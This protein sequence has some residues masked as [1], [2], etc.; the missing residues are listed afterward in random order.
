MGQHIDR[1]HIDEAAAA[2]AAGG[3]GSYGVDNDD[4]GGRES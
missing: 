2:T 1:V 4:V 3:G